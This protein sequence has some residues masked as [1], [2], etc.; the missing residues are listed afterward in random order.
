V[1]IVLDGYQILY[2]KATGRY[3]YAEQ[4]GYQILYSKTSGRYQIATD[5][6]VI[7]THGHLIL[8][9]M[10]SGTLYSKATVRYQIGTEGYQILYSKVTLGRY[11]PDPARC[12]ILY[13][14]LSGIYP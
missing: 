8:C 11:Q 2:S 3:P 12:Q 1:D 7:C 4:D 13:S 9:S 6:C 5:G 14:S 10:A